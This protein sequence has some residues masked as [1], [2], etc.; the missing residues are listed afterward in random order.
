MNKVS[1]KKL[2]F[3]IFDRKTIKLGKKGVGMIQ[4]KLKRVS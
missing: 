3:V 1:Q 2:K 4:T